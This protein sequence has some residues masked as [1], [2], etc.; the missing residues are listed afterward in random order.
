MY[1]RLANRWRRRSEIKEIEL[2]RGGVE[3]DKE[4]IW[5]EIKKFYQKVY[6][7]EKRSRPCI[8]GA[9]W[10]PISITK[11]EKIER[12][13]EE[14]EVPNLFGAT[15][16]EKVPGLDGFMGAFF[17]SCWDIITDNLMKVFQ[18]SYLNGAY[19]VA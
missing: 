6:T 12:P 4:V 7:E 9:A 19:V 1:H 11:A 13:F 2:E 3:Q 17:Q 10:L 16:T 5:S 15:C 14:K 8:E 18:E